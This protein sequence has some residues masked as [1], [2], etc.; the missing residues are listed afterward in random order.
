MSSTQRFRAIQAVRFR[1]SPTSWLVPAS[2]AGCRRLPNHCASWNVLVTKV[3]SHAQKDYSKKS[4]INFRACGV[5][6]TNFSKL[7]RTL[8]HEENLHSN[9]IQKDP[10]PGRR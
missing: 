5:S 1:A 10:H 2:P 4:A 7:C 6:L 9:E 3:T 8:I